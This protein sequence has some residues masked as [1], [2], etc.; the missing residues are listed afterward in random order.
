MGPHLVVR[1]G[2]C[3]DCSH[4]TLRESL[5]L[6]APSHLGEVRVKGR[7]MASL[8]PKDEGPSLNLSN[9][10]LPLEGLSFLCVCSATAVLGRMEMIQHCFFW[11]DIK[12]VSTTTPL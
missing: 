6:A 11:T 1:V 7:E 2:L 10:Q 4:F 9:G 5:D 8:P 12:M 3:E